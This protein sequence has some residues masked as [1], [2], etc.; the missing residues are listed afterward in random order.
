MKVK[1]YLFGLILISPI[2]GCEKKELVPPSDKVE[3]EAPQLVT[4]TGYNDHIMEPFLSRDGT[5]LFFNNSNHPSALTNIHYA[6]RVSDL[7]FIYQGELP[8]V[9]SDDLDGVPAMDENGNFYFVSTRSYFTTLSSIYSGKFENN[10]VKEIKLVEGISK[11]LFGWLNF[12][13][14]ISRDG[15]FLYFVDGRFDEN[16]G[17]YESNLGI[18]EKAGNIFVRKAN[19]GELKYINTKSL[20]YAACI[21]SDMLELYFTRVDAPISINSIPRIFYANRVSV[22]KPFRKPYEINEMEGFVEAAT[23][24]PDNRIIYYHKLE[25]DLYVLYMVKKK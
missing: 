6:L 21:S 1:Y 19:Q 9:N 4:I 20:E 13:V 12:D 14:E 7:S 2:N 23:V 8:G 24:S 3:F 10:E 5:I 22:N 16:G 15:S 17:P 11:N 18:A 25:G